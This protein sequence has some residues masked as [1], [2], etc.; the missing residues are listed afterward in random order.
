MFDETRENHC[1]KF[2][3]FQNDDIGMSNSK[4]DK[5]TNYHLLISKYKNKHISW[6]NTIWKNIYT[7]Y[8]YFFL[9]YL[10]VIFN[11]AEIFCLYLDRRKMQCV[12]FWVFFFRTYSII[13]MTFKDSGI[14]PDNCNKMV[15]LQCSTLK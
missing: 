1:N 14:T 12:V 10:R 13:V 6:Y 5:N 8:H 7:A 11:E 4:Y 2:M 15:K 3:Q 9:H